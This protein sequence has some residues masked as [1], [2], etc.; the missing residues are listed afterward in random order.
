MAASQVALASPWLRLS[1]FL[2]DT[3]ILTV[4]NLGVT[5]S[6]G[7]V[8]IEERTTFAAITFV[9]VAYHVGFVAVR[10][11]T[12]GKTL[13]GI[14]VAYPDGKPVRPDTAILRYLVFNGPLY[15]GIINVTLGFVG[16]SIWVASLLLVLIEP[17]RRTMH[18]RIAGT[19]V[20]VG[21]PDEALADR[22]RP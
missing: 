2:I 15:L 11:A 18:D 16:I 8:R 9:W 10:S 14:Y 6:L 5:A 12:L 20:L 7:D 22:F 3:A 13:M 19:R 17:Q 4:I 1:A 21:R